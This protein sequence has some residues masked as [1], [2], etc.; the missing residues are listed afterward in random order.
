MAIF[1]SYV[2]LPEG[3][4]V[5]YVRLCKIMYFFVVN[6]IKLYSIVPLLEILVG[7]LEHWLFFHI[8]GMIIPFDELHHFLEGWAQP[9]TS[10]IQLHM[11][12]PP[13]FHGITMPDWRWGGI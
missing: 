7:G 4:Y 5:N 8:L 1:N 10:N 6:R 3:I 9:P 2:K 13:K 11:I 12:F